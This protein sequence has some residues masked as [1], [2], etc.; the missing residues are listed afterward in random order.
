MFS[1]YWSKLPLPRWLGGSGKS[2][3]FGDHP[4]ALKGLFKLEVCERMSYYGIV[5]L[6]VLFLKTRIEDGGFGYSEAWA[7]TIFA[8]Y[9]GLIYLTPLL[10]GFLA[11]RWFGARRVMLAGAGVIAFGHFCVAF[12]SQT[13]FFAGL[14]LIALGTGMLK[15]NVNTLVSQLYKEMDPRRSAGFNLLYMGIN[16]GAAMARM[17]MLLDDWLPEPLAVAT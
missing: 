15:P 2:L 12:Q 1:R 3:L 10:G 7:K 4:D 17:R 6:L 14:G 5:S 11:D 13:A 8:T 9:T 16:I